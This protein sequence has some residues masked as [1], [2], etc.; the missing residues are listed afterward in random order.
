MGLK[1][2]VVSLPTSSDIPSGVTSQN[3]TQNSTMEIDALQTDPLHRGGQPTNYDDKKSGAFWTEEAVH[4][5]S[6]DDNGNAADV[7]PAPSNTAFGWRFE[8]LA[9]AFSV[10]CILSI[11]AILLSFQDRPKDEW[12]GGPLSITGAIA[13]F[14]TGANLSAAL[15]IGACISQYKWLHFRK[16]PH[17]LADLDVLEEASRGPLGSL[18]LLIKRP[19]GLASIGAVVTLLA[20]GV[21]NQ[22][23]ICSPN[24]P[25]ICRIIWEFVTEV[26][27]MDGSST[28]S[29]SSWS[30][31]SR[32]MFPRTMARPCLGWHTR[33]TAAPGHSLT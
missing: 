8:L 10:G 22:P 24:S 2:D 17:R 13:I 11:V 18:L 3:K 1:S 29:S 28:P 25:K 4:S 31:S 6:S 32:V 16:A 21:G 5:P 30:T 19:C 12:H 26:A 9:L 15:A 33:T 7:S 27:D 20:L 14:S 23:F